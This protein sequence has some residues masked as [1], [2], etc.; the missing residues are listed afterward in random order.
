MGGIDDYADE[1]IEET[2][3]KK[4]VSLEEERP[5]RKAFHYWKVGDREYKLKLTT[6]MIEKVEGKYRTTNL[7]NLISNE[8][9]PAL[10]VML[11]IIQAAMSPWE[12]KLSYAK[13]QSIY[14]AYVDDGG[15]QMELLTKV[16]MPTLS[17]SGFF[18]DRVVESMQ[19]E[20]ETAED[21][22]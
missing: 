18:T 9:L 12:H 10:S 21:L 2:E 8:G 5:K 13:V 7:M 1:V 15:N 3:S 22:I 17:V 6:A 11:T 14:D 16:V 4:I 20:L 19:K